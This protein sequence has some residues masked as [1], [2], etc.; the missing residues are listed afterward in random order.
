[1]ILC[2]SEG[3]DATVGIRSFCRRRHR[4]E[5]C[6]LPG[7]RWPSIA[8]SDEECGQKSRFSASLP[9]IYHIQLVAIPHPSAPLTPSPRGRVFPF[10]ASIMLC[11]SEGADAT[12]G[13]RSFCR[14]RR[15]KAVLC[16]MRIATPVC[17][18]ARND[19]GFRY[20]LV[21]TG[22]P[23]GPVPTAHKGPSRMPVPTHTHR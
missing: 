9:G 20:T 2:H 12:V 19:K 14:R 13:I 7:R 1:M 21:G 10:A 15:R 6:L 17:A 18:L 11:H 3:A 16:K 5:L 4:R 8:R 23:D 22:L